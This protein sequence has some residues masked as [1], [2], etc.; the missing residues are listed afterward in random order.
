[1]KVLA[2]DPGYGRC[3]MAILERESGR[4][5]LRHSE[6]V[7]TLA[8][9]E[10]VDRLRVICE[11][12]T[13]LM[14]EFAPDAFAIEKLFFSANQKTAMRV[15]EVRGALINCATSFGI[16]VFEY[17]PAQVKSATAGSGRA[18]KQQIAAV[19]RMVIKID[20]EIRYDDEYDAIAVG[21]THLAFSKPVLKNVVY[22]RETR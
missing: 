5:V 14:E 2:I 17:T 6:C 22:H 1:M 8:E 4:D 10:F 7:E 21:V 20:K 16:D 18:D 11:A 19:L 12:C 13:R 9:E 15:A 3:G